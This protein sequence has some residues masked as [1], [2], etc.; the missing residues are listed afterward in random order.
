M[1]WKEVSVMSS[2]REFVQLAT[3]PQANIAQLCRRFGISRNTGH[4]LI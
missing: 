4:K 3:Q 2:R 1:P